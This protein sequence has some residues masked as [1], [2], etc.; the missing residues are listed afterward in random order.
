MPPLACKNGIAK[1][2]AL[3]LRRNCSTD[4]DYILKSRQFMAYL[5]ARGH[6]PHIIYTVFLS[7]LNTP[8]ELTRKKKEKS[9]NVAFKFIT[10]YNPVAPNIK[11]IL[12]KNLNILYSDKRVKNII[13][14]IS[15]VHKRCKNLSELIMRADPY[16]IPEREPV[17]GGWYLT[18]WKKL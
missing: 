10:K 7:I 17:E 4:A 13:P 16:N 14:T 8:R 3:R 11:Q 12:N 6:D 18:L 9:P 2:V 5:A 15:V 1:G